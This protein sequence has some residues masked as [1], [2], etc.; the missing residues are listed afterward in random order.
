MDEVCY[1]RM[2]PDQIVAARGLWVAS[3]SMHMLI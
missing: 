2:L 1:E 3:S